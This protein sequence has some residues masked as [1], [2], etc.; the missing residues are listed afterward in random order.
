MQ[1]VI[2][3]YGGVKT[4]LAL[5]DGALHAGTVQDCSAIAEYTKAR[6]NEGLTGS[7]E[8]RLAA[9]MPLVMVEKYCNDRGITFHEFSGSESHKK[10]L[11]NDP[12]LA[13]F[14]IWNGRL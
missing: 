12:A 8:M 6:Q 2:E 11:L 13:H 10:A 14:R 5:E 3:H 9:S 1:S 4:V 7:S